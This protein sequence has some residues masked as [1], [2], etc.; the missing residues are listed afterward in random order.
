MTIKNTLPNERSG[1]IFPKMEIMEMNYFQDEQIWRNMGN[2]DKVTIISSA[3]GK[4]KSTT[5]KRISEI[6]DAKLV[7]R[8]DTKILVIDDPD[9]I[10]IILI[11][12]PH[13]NGMMDVLTKSGK[14][15]TFLVP[16]TCPCCGKMIDPKNA[17]GDDVH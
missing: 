7:T 2:L 14:F 8:K 11:G 15:R 16:Y 6:K 13:K 1:M 17:R 9:E 4:G 10:S 5:A 12:T 3:R